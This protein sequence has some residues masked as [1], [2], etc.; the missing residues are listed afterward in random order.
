MTPRVLTS[1]YVGF[2]PT[3]PHN[4]AGWRMEPAVSEPKA[5]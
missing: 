4:E 2:R 5:P 3:M 1:P